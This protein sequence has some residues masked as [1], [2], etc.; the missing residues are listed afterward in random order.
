MLRNLLLVLLLVIFV[1]VRGQQKGQAPSKLSP[2]LQQLILSKTSTDSIDVS[3]TLKKASPLKGARILSSP[4]QGFLLVIRLP[5]RD[6]A[7]VSQSGDVIFMQRVI[8]PKE[9]VNTGTSDP[10]LNLLTYA[11]N[12]FPQVRGN[13]IRSSVKE[14]LLDTTDIDLK[15]RIFTTGLENAS[16]T[17]HASLMATIMAGAANTSPFAKGA[18]PAAAVTSSSFANLFPDPDS[19]FRKYTI[20]VQNHSYGT[21]VENFYG[22][23]A[24]AYDQNAIGNPQLLHVF[25]AGNSGSVTNTT[26][27]YAGVTNMANLSGDFKQA[28]NL[29]TVSA[30]DSAGQLLLLSSKGPAF[31]GRVKPELVAYGEDGSSGAAAL[32][33][34]SVILVQ[35]LYSRLHAGILPLSALVKAVLLNSADDAGE[36]HVDYKA[37][38]GL[39]NAYRALQTVTE[40]HFMEGTVAQGQTQTFTINAPANAAQVKLTLVW[41]DPPATPN[42]PKALV[43]DLDLVLR[44]AS[45]EA[46]LPWVLSPKQVLDSVLSPAQ[47]K[48]DTLN[49]VEQISVNNPAAGTYTVEIKGSRLIS[50]S[51]SFA[52]AY[53]I[54]TANTFYW[55]YPTSTDHLVAGARQAL[56][57]H[58]NITGSG[59]VEYATTGNNWRTIGEVDTLTK[60]YL[61]WAVPDT[62]T[63]AK[64]RMVTTSTDFVSDTFTINPL[65][66]LK[67][68]FNCVD[69][70]LLYWQSLPVN[71]YR[72]YNLGEKYLEPFLQLPDTAVVLLK[73]QHP[74]LFYSVAPLINGREGIRSNAV[75]YLFQGVGCYLRSFYLQS[76]TTTTASLVAELGSVYNVADV[77][78]EKFNGTGFV[79]LQTIAA[80]QTISFAFNDLALN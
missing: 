23:E 29:L 12:R 77:S 75:N 69:S 49:N 58:T 63:N 2:E 41:T 78:L 61:K 1:S 25:S 42:A 39:L 6:L 19:I 18:A 36:K 74:S 55:T 50:A 21:A 34:G 66:S 27:P 20:S 40:N 30:V 71:Q 65:Q 70:F 52:I 32:T 13:G 11:Q 33:S 48:V 16:V 3:V 37:G 79:T 54:D 17:T 51:Q 4:V 14:R 31:D 5:T 67:T 28:K 9:E 68:G 43:N 26:G 10:T 8:Q 45:N 59:K 60:N 46:W 64:L 24:A 44:S 22:N 73:A 38:Y 56:R 72:L 80:P 53:G 47:R 35:D 62:V 57:W 15:G 76:Q 7:A